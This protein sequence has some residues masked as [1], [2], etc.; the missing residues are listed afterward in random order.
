MYDHPLYRLLHDEPNPEMTSFVFRETLM[1]HLL[2][3]VIA[4]AQIIRDGNGRVG[5]ENQD[6]RW[7]ILQSQKILQAFKCC[8]GLSRY[9]Q[10][11]FMIL[12]NQQ[13]RIKD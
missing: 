3:F 11:V 6:E 7:P 10:V 12:Y 4:Y 2:V 9:E 8:A 5:M 1:S 13:N